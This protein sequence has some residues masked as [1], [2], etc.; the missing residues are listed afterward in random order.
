[1]I[2]NGLNEWRNNQE[3]KPKPK[4]MHG[5]TEA[6]KTEDT[7]TR[8]IKQQREQ[9]ALSSQN[10][11][12]AKMK[13]QVTQGELSSLEKS[14]K[15]TLLHNA[16]LIDQKNIAEQL[17]N[18]PRRSGDS[19]TAAR[20]RGNIDFLGAGQGDKARDRMKEMADIRAD[21]LRQQRDYNVISVVG[22]FPKTCIKSKRKRLKQRLPNAWIFRRS[23]TKKPMNSSQTGRAGISD[24]LMNYADQASDL[25]SMAATATKRNSGCHH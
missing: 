15:E 13:Y 16:A 8:L 10:T 7:Y 1:M 11:E 21:F 2:N 17:K 6:E 19:N 3:N 23:I 20:E 24:S 12:L 14:K 4:G 18:I 9:I 5:K 22:R 25:S